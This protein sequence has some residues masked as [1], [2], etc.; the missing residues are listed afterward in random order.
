MNFI[1]NGLIVLSMCALA[2]AT[3]TAKETITKIGKKASGP[4]QNREVIVNFDATLAKPLPVEFEPDEKQI[5][6]TINKRQA[7]TFRFKNTSDK[8]IDVYIVH[9]IE[10]MEAAVAF[11]KYE[12]FCF[13]E[14]TLKANSEIHMKLDFKVTDALP[15]KFKNFKVSYKMYEKKDPNIKPMPKKHQHHHNH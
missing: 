13:T 10:P 4:K 2:E 8:D 1:L 6:P 15:K 14:Q 3:L 5:V 9:D 7:T 12:C 11:K